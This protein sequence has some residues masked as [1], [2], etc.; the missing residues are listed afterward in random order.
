MGLK[1]LSVRTAIGAV[2]AAVPV[3]VVAGVAAVVV[4]DSF[5][6]IVVVDDVLLFLEGAFFVCFCRLCCSPGRSVGKLY[7]VVMR[8]YHIIFY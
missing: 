7:F 6:L 5:P 4:V 2:V 8:V 1:V 3:A